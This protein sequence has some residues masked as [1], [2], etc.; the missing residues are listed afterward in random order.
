VLRE[1]AAIARTTTSGFV[2]LCVLRRP[3]ELAESCEASAL[4]AEAG[5]TPKG[6]VSLLL[7]ERHILL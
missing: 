2:A 6:V 7:S 1:R 5:G 4:E 3:R